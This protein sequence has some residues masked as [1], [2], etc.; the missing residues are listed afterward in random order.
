MKPITKARL[1]TRQERLRDRGQ[2]YFQS[3]HLLKDLKGRSL[4]G[5]V[6]TLGGQAARFLLG[7]VSTAALARLLRPQDFGLLAM[8]TSITAFV[9]LFK[10]L[11]L[12]NATVQRSQVTHAQVSFLFWVN[13]ALSLAV[14]LVV[15]ALAPAIAWFYHEPRLFW[16]TVALALNFIFSGVT[17]QHL[18]LL[19]R[20]MQFKALAIRDVIAMA[21]GIAVGIT[22]AWLGFGYWALVAVPITTNLVASALIWAI[23]DWRPSAFRRRVGARAMLAFGGNLTAFNVFNYF[24][25]NFDNILIGRV[26]GSGALGIYTK[27]YGL[28]ML[29]IAQIN[30]PMASVMLPGLSRLQNDPSEYAKL[31]VSA[32]RAIGLVTIPIVIFSFFLSQDIVLVL[33]GRKWL[34]VAPVFRLLAPAAL[35]GAISFAPGWLCQS[36]GRSRRQLHYAL[37]S[38]P[39]C[40]GGFLVGIKW[41]IAG[42]AVSYSITSSFCFWGYMWYSCK[43]S[44]VTF[45]EMGASFVAALL[46]S[47][48]AGTV[49]WTL[50]WSLIYSVQPIVALILLGLVFSSIYLAAAMVT[51]KNRTIILSGVNSFLGFTASKWDGQ[52]S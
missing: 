40:V 7:L 51:Q 46:P 34:S 49:V 2:H 52:R 16:I 6:V 14:T 15:L 12:S 30:M 36:L 39:I 33:L 9:Q 26:L 21:C 48:V 47:L 27:S 3:E 45:S 43:D 23:C 22:F 37:I 32:V 13:V 8:V 5:G 10:D 20:Q 25:L 24:T 31:F 11:G 19:R 29:P 41:G 50:R 1:L 38:M 17:V 44:P 28:L 42:I 18:A 35:F 4:R